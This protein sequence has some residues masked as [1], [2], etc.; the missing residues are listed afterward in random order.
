MRSIICREGI[1]YCAVL[2][3]VF[4][5]AIPREANLLLLFGSLL[6]CPLFISW[7]LERKTIS[8]LT[9][10]RK[11]PLQVI[12]GDIF[13]VSIELTNTRRKLSSWAIVVE[14][15]I[16]LERSSDSANHE[17]KAHSKESQSVLKTETQILKPAVYFEF[18]KTGSTIKK[19]YSGCLTRRGRY[20][21]GPISLSTRFPTGFF[22]TTL[23]IDE[24]KSRETKSGETSHEFLVFPRI[25]QLSAHWF[26]RQ[27]QS[28]EN[29]QKRR[30]FQASRVGG[31]FLGV[32]HWQSGDVKKWIH[33]RASAKHNK[34]V[35]R[36]FEQHQNRDAAVVLDLF[37]RNAPSVQDLELVELAVSF[38][39]T[40]VNELTKRRGASLT[41]GTVGNVENPENAENAESDIRTAILEGQICLPLVDQIMER[42]AT[43]SPTGEDTLMELLLNILSNSD[44]SADIFLVS[45]GPLNLTQSRR[46]Q[47]FQ[48][49][50]RIRTLAQR[51]R[52][53]DVSSPEL[54]EIY[55][56]D[57]I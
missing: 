53:I 26:A 17:I 46:F 56:A 51:I 38:S 9:V 35:V 7:R 2:V 12:A 37:Q 44:P 10:K 55:I 5:G 20:K 43:I 8:G 27:H 31:E 11:K 45:P 1:Y 39:A 14:D 41:F 13:H 6:V 49:D 15:T 28:S 21:L 42:L 25:G 18:I 30:R 52:L 57:S 22:R 4:F 32:R 47:E 24:T 54:D 29:Q 23:Q 3:L 40:L 19:S 33:W 50:P 16:Q 34:L 48:N 36:Q